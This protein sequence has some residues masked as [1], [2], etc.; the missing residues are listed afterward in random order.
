MLGPVHPGRRLFAR[1]G[2]A[3]RV[4]RIPPGRPLTRHR[5][6]QLGAYRDGPGAVVG[7]GLLSSLVQHVGH[8]HQL[9]DE[10]NGGGRVGDDRPEGPPRSR[11]ALLA[12]DFSVASGSDRASRLRY[13]THQGIK[14]ISFDPDLPRAEPGG[15]QGAGCDVVAQRPFMHADVFGS[16]SKIEP[17]LARVLSLCDHGNRPCL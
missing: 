4:L 7:P 2:A 14:I 13:R 11:N 12:S 6:E 9:D 8:P 5:A 3:S 1:P 15:C 17:L 10:R 16:A